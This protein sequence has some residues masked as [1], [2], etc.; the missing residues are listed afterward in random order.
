MSI[1]HHESDVASNAILGLFA[2]AVVVAVGMGITHSGK[3]ANIVP[4]QTASR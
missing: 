4:I 2:L 1:K 3:T